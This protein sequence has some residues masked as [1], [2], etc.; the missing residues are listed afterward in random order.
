MRAH[1]QVPVQGVAGLEVGVRA[2]LE[3]RQRRRAR[4]GCGA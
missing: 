4:R 3:G 1:A 2:L